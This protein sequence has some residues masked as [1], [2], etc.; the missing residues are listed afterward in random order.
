MPSGPFSAG[1]RERL[2][3]A[4]VW[5]LAVDFSGECLVL[6]T[7][8]ARQHADGRQ[9]PRAGLSRGDNQEMVLISFKWLL[10]QPAISALVHSSFQLK[11]QLTVTFLPGAVPHS[12]SVTFSRR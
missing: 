7:V 12:L 6:A 1:L 5:K 2:H 9:D 10:V 11:N 4:A 3:L 8:R